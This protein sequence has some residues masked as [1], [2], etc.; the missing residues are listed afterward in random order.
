MRISIYKLLETYLFF[1][2]L[3][4]NMLNNYYN[5]NLAFIDAFTFLQQPIYTIKND[6]CNEITA[7]MILY[8][9][10]RKLLYVNIISSTVLIK[11]TVMI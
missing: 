4:K 1:K 5:W 9:N 10:K 3:T 11:I 8:N 7:A 2:L 6:N